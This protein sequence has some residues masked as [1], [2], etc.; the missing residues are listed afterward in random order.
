MWMSLEVRMGG[1]LLLSEICHLRPMA[2]N[3]TTSRLSR[4]ENDAL[5]RRAGFTQA[6]VHQARMVRS[7]DIGA[8]AARETVG[9]PNSPLATDFRHPGR[10]NSYIA[11]RD[12]GRRG[13][14][15]NRL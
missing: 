11:G 8:V 10:K 7:R 15:P 9:W 2:V 1:G 6:T 3:A 5:F 4:H 12:L 13:K 14:G